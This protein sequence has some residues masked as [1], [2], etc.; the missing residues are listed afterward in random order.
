[1]A[2]VEHRL[3]DKHLME[4]GDFVQSRAVQPVSVAA[5]QA[6]RINPHEAVSLVEP[7]LRSRRW[8]AAADY[9]VLVKPRIMV[10][11]LI[12]TLAAALIAA[13]TRPEGHLEVLRLVCLT[14]IGGALASGGASA[15]NHFI[16]RDIDAVMARTKN[17]PLPSGRLQPINALVFGLVLTALSFAVFAL[18]VNYLSALLA[19]AGNFYYVVI[20]TCW[21]KRLTPQN[22]VIGGVAGAIPP[23]VGWAAVRDDVA[24][25]ALLLFLIITLWTPPHFWSLSIL[26]QKD[27]TRAGI[28]MLPVVRGLDKT[29]WNI[30]VYTG[31]LVASTLLLSATQAMGWFYLAMAIAL[32]GYFLVQTGLLLRQAT[33]ARA[34][35]CFMYS[36][37]YLGLLFAAMVVDRLLALR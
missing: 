27:Y 7:K 13:S 35:A 9:F 15:L 25:P 26:T 2:T 31:I 4:W 29:R 33:L 37:L 17:R 1:V 21:L 30:F 10:L 32:G 22:I 14:L 20:Y 23:L 16:D 28:P 11:L 19:L 8:A 18:W 5:E 12:T 36:N 24:L 6:P 34:R 3:T